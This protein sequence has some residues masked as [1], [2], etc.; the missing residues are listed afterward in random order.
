MLAFPDVVHFLADEFTTLRRG[1]LS[2]SRIL[3]RALDRFA[4]RHSTLRE[5]RHP[6]PEAT[7]VPHVDDNAEESVAVS[8]AERSDREDALRRVHS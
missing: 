2:F 7:T 8:G 1:G 5:L 6:T 3:T 4:F